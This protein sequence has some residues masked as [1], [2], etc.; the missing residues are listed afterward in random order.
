MPWLIEVNHSPSFTCDTP[1]D[2][3]IKHQLI[4]RTL[5]LLMLSSSDKNAAARRAA[6]P[7]RRLYGNDDSAVTH[8]VSTA[9]A[10]ERLLKNA[11]NTKESR[12]L[13]AF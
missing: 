11:K 7:K 2:A 8:R 5:S 6:D 1:L 9:D 13:M 4:D 3:S 10:N 12:P